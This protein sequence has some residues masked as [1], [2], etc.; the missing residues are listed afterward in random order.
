MFGLFYTLTFRVHLICYT[1]CWCRTQCL[2]PVN[3]VIGV[4][5][6]SYTLRLSSQSGVTC[7]GHVILP[8]QN[9]HAMPILDSLVQDAVFYTN[10]GTLDTVD[11]IIFASAKFRDFGV[12]RLIRV[13]LNSR[14]SA[15]NISGDSRKYP[16]I[17]VKFPNCFKIF[18]KK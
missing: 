12:I 8:K 3:Q 4:E 2:V 15:S 6:V 17:F 13:V 14:L 11:W 16:L 18:G 1:K 7:A 9:V 5:L 10:T